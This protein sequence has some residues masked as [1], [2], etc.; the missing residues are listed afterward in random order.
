[1]V[2]FNSPIIVLVYFIEFLYFVGYRLSFEGADPN[3]FIGL[4]CKVRNLF[5]SSQVQTHEWLI[6][7]GAFVIF[8]LL[9]YISL[10]HCIDLFILVD[11]L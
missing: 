11:D 7:V 3:K 1:M 4:Q 9:T 8:F 10:L 5:N 6:H 2:G